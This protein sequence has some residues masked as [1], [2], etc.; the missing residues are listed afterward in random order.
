[1]E[2]RI[3]SKCNT[4]K[5]ETFFTRRK[6]H[7]VGKLVSVCT[8]CKV[9][10][11][12]TRRIE[13]PQNVASIE[14]RSKFK[15][16]YGITLEKYYE[17]LAS[18]DNKCAICKADTPNKRTKFFAIDHCHTTG[19]VRGLLCSSCNRGLGL[20]KDSTDSLSKAIEYLKGD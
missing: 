1:M 10:Y 19:K 13:N 4:L 5:D 14:R 11:N 16:I 6:T 8:P 15:N 12:R 9:E 17:M 7:R 2:Q 3:C 18:Q 20:F